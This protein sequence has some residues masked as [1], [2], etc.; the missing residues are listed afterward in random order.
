MGFTFHLSFFVWF[1]LNTSRLESIRPL[2]H[3]GEAD[4]R[5]AT[6]H[7]S[8]AK[9][10]QPAQRNGSLVEVGTRHFAKV[11]D[12]P[13]HPPKEDDGAPM[14]DDWEETGAQD[15]VNSDEGGDMQ[16]VSD[17]RQGENEV[18]VQGNRPADPTMGDPI[19]STSHEEENDG[20]LMP[21]V[22]SGAAPQH[23]DFSF[24]P[25]EPWSVSANSEEPSH[26]ESQLRIGED[27]AGP[28]D[29]RDNHFQEFL[30]MKPRVGSAVDMY[31]EN[32]AK[33][34]NH[35]INTY[36]KLGES[37]TAI[38]RIKTAV[39]NVDN[40][41]GNL[42]RSLKMESRKEAL[43]VVDPFMNYASDGVWGGSRGQKFQPD[44]GKFAI[45]DKL[46]T[47]AHDPKRNMSY[48]GNVS[49]SE[50]DK[51]AALKQELHAL[52]SE[53]KAFKAAGQA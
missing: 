46:M 22:N 33:T 43:R 42:K 26:R 44:A 6:Q 32:I 2:D 31:K 48:Y 50:S 36:N 13:Q 23:P 17:D 34:K 53:V 27:R 19:S 16:E 5:A 20:V 21:R 35:A 39:D 28:N 10:T 9:S 47:E 38:A 25:L 49:E 7:G 51:L 41:E 15:D 52:K 8:S 11:P 29:E 45:F 40:E 1:F 14:E 3:S 18:Q 4:A 24:N 37:V 12:G 30:T